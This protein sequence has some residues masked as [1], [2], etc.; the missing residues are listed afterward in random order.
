VSLADHSTPFIRSLS[1]VAQIPTSLLTTD[2]T[3][4]TPNSDQVRFIPEQAT[5][6]KRSRAEQ[7]P[8]ATREKAASAPIVPLSVGL[9][10]PI[11]DEST[12]KSPRT[13]SQ[14]PSRSPARD[15][16]V[17]QES[18][19]VVA[20]PGTRHSFSG[21][22]TLF[23]SFLVDY[24]SEQNEVRHIVLKEALGL[25]F[26]SF[27]PESDSHLQTHFIS[28]VQPTSFADKAGL[29]DGDRI[30][31]VNGVDVT[32]AIHEDVRRMMQEKKPLQLTVINDPRYLELIENV[33]R[34]Q[35]KTEGKREKI[36]SAPPDYES[37]EQSQNFSYF[38]SFS[39]SLL[40]NRSQRP[41]SSKRRKCSERFGQ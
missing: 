8:V 17:S 27:I 6:S 34:S 5:S 20:K 26:N 19:P 41:L 15:I 18:K 7:S 33:K 9:T 28:N 14:S 4:D 31:T 40:S 25:D 39:L 10:N 32:N 38:D 29:R 2:I 23:L 11:S 37:S 21:R 12:T 22:T 36:T 30:L 24:D 3:R 1:S 35:G 16:S 13:Q